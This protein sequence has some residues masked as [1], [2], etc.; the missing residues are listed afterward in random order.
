ML[1]TQKKKK[2]ESQ[3]VV[4]CLVS[5]SGDL[6]WTPEPHKYGMRTESI[7]LSSDIHICSMIGVHTHTLYKCTH[8]HP[9]TQ[10]HIYYDSNK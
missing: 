5:K 2:L 9:N 4:R 3:L 8:V 7:K 1:P 10:A 6:S